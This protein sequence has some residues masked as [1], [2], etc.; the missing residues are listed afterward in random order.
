MQISKF[1]E[2]LAYFDSY[3]IFYIRVEN[4]EFFQKFQLIIDNNIQ[5]IWTKMFNFRWNKFLNTVKNLQLKHL[6]NDTESKLTTNT[7]LLLFQS[8]IDLSNEISKTTFMHINE[9]ILNVNDLKLAKIF[10]FP[11]NY[12]SGYNLKS[13]EM[14]QYRFVAERINEFEPGNRDHM[15]MYFYIV[16][17]GFYC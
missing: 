6:L 12:N 3:K 7:Y 11:S 14:I 16:I 4:I 17:F 9:M 10:H 8:F 2:D 1:I 13:N 15:I 5:P